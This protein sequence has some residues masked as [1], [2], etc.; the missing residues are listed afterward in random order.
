[1]TRLVLA[2]IA[3]HGEL[4]A[5]TSQTLVLAT[6]IGMMNQARA[7][8]SIG[9]GHANRLQHHGLGQII[10]QAPANNASREAIHKYRQVTEA[11]FSDGNVRDVAH[12]KSID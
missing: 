2:D 9:D 5:A 4:L 10:A 6:A 7:R 8:I 3:G 12:P 1:M 11:N